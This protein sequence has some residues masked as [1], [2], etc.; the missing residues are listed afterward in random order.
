VGRTDIG[1]ESVFMKEDL[2]LVKAV[3]REKLVLLG[4]SRTRP[5]QLAPESGP[6]VAAEVLVREGPDD[7]EEEEKDDEEKDDEENEDD[8]K[9]DEGYSE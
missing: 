7:E 8:E 5:E 6:L 3:L 1:E 4:V 2:K 9:E